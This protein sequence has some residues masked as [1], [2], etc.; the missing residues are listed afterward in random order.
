MNKTVFFSGIILMLTIYFLFP[1]HSLPIP[2]ELLRESIGQMIVAFI[3][4]FL[5]IFGAV[6]NDVKGRVSE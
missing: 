3:G 2:K 6:L 1:N 5:I 4:F